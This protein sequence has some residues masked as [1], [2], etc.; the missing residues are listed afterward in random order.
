MDLSIYMGA[1]IVSL[2]R[3]RVVSAKVFF[4]M[5]TN[6]WCKQDEKIAFEITK[7]FTLLMLCTTYLLFSKCGYRFFTIINHTFWKT[8]ILIIIV[9]LKKFGGWRIHIDSDILHQL[10][11]T[12]VW[13]QHPWSAEKTLVVKAIIVKPL[14]YSPTSTGS[15]KTAK[16]KCLQRFLNISTDILLQSNLGSPIIAIYEEVSAGNSQVQV[17][18]VTYP[19]CVHVVWRVARTKFIMKHKTHLHVSVCTHTSARAQGRC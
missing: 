6:I 9:I 16:I 18:V 4:V 12:H 13:L 1:W 19:I 10:P 3:R 15:V 14:N 11:Y 5:V 8:H 2:F 7:L 17:Q